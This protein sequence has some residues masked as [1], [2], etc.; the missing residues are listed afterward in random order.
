MDLSQNEGAACSVGLETRAAVK[1]WNLS[2]SSRAHLPS[3]GKSMSAGDYLI[4][5]NACASSCKKNRRSCQLC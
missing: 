5:L 3:P 1:S 4:Y 2:G